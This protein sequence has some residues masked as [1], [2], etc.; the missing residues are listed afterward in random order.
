MGDPL[1]QPLATMRTRLR[2]MDEA[3]WREALGQRDGGVYQKV[4]RVLEGLE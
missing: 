1:G 4:W 3:G 2:E